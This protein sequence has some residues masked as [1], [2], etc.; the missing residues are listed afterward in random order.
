MNDSRII[1]ATTESRIIEITPDTEA[2]YLAARL[3]DD[4]D[5]ARDRD[6]LV[7]QAEI[8]CDA[9]TRYWRL[10]IAEG[11]GSD[12]VSAFAEGNIHALATLLR[13]IKPGVACPCALCSNGKESR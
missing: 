5:K 3:A 11:R 7:M 1:E 10:R 4:H 13:S 6:F 12:A 2:R 9:W 8:D